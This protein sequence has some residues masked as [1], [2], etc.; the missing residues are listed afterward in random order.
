MEVTT[1]MDALNRE[2]D[3]PSDSRLAVPS[4]HPESFKA[5][6]S[7]P[8]R[9]DSDKTIVQ[10]LPPR[11]SVEK[12]PMP[13][14]STS[15]DEPTNVTKPTPVPKLLPSSKGLAKKLRHGPT[16]VFQKATS[17]IKRVASAI[18]RLFAPPQTPPNVPFLR[19]RLRNLKK[20]AK[21]HKPFNFDDINTTTLPSSSKTVTTSQS[22][23]PSPLLPSPP[24]DTQPPLLANLY[25]R[26]AITKSFLE[27]FELGDVL[28]SGAFGVIMMAIQR[29]DGQEVAVKFIDKDKMPEDFWVPDVTNPDGHKVPKEVAIL[30]EL[31]HP[32]IIGYICHFDEEHHIVLVT[33]RHG[34]EWYSENPELSLEKNP[35]LRRASG[36]SLH[37]C[38]SSG[39]GAKQVRQRVS[40]DLFECIDV[41]RRLPDATCRKIFAQVALTMEYLHNRGIVHRDIK[42]ENVVIDS[43]Y[44]I[45]LI[46]FGSASRTASRDSEWF[47][48]FNGTAHFAS[49]EVAMGEPYRGPEAE[50]WALGCLLFTLVYGENP[51]LD[52]ADVTG[53]QYVFP[54]SLPT[55]GTPYGPQSL[56]RRLL[57]YYPERRATIQEVVNHPWIAEEVAFLEQKGYRPH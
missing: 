31:R 52:I 16:K 23:A 24:T 49:P 54:F 3:S 43:S 10:D 25:H 21:D 42:D 6:P 19:F 51:F 47:T 13:A 32:G 17:Y 34:T 7:S 9:M 29:S 11:D 40:C 18:T 14:T 20:K 5:V 26:K 12:L 15:L 2:V 28:G 22:E 4:S 46:D 45:K 57:T 53:G 55:D 8:D 39:N 41:H 35:G 48:T 36:G 37:G 38:G 33:E 44:T 27:R 50:M 1:S 56:V 30:R